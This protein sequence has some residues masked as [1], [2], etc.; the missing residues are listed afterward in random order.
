MAVHLGDGSQG[1]HNGHDA[2][3]DEL[4]EQNEPVQAQ[5]LPIAELRVV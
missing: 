3:G 1:D 2:H 4:E 5:D